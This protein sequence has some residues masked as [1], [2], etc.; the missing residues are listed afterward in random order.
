MNFRV[1]FLLLTILSLTS[2]LAPYKNIRTQE[3]DELQYPFPVKYLQ[4]D[5]TTRIAYVDEGSGE[6]TLVF[7]H[8]LGSYLPAWKKNIA[9]LRN[10]FRCIALDL[11]GYGKSS[12]GVYPFSMSYYAEVVHRFL[13]EL[14][15]T[16]VIVVGHSMGGQIAMTLAL[17]YPD[18]VEKLVLIAPA[19][20]ERFSEGEKKWFMQ[21]MTVDGVRLTPVQQ[22]RKNF[23]LNF[24][25][26]P[27]D[28]EFMIRD[29]IALRGARDFEKYCYAVVKS[30]EG[31]LK[32]PVYDY[33]EEI[34][35]PTLIIFG[36]NDN[37]IPNP[38]LHGGRSR[39][40]GRIGDEKIPNSTLKLI[41]NSG[42]FVHYESAEE[43]NRVIEE[44][45][46]ME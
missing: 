20:L 36:E 17:L 13:Q 32:E 11:P 26:F 40:I 24:Y 44:F 14:N 35:S 29:R 27:A 10:Q 28:A 3:F 34:Q 46:G 9:G 25:N 16:N 33:L 4:L 1:I 12:K 31:M 15:L 39:D 21:V 37:L 42:H 45:V 8:G 5:D 30:V 43:V 2:C 38:Y 23:Y 7:V 18:E 41:P 19:G 22:I 6:K